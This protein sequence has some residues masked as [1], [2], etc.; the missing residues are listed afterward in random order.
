MED[1]GAKVSEGV[2]DGVLGTNSL[3][4]RR[5]GIWD[6]TEDD[7]DSVVLLQRYW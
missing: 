7:G 4:S 2:G 6:S 5:E 3:S 1:S